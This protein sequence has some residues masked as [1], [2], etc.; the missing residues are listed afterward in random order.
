MTAD[1]PGF[2]NGSAIGAAVG[3]VLGLIVVGT[4]MRLGQQR[5]RVRELRSKVSELENRTDSDGPGPD[6]S[7]QQVPEK[8]PEAD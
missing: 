8:A 2:R 1:A 6:A 4:S 7:N 3:L 5:K